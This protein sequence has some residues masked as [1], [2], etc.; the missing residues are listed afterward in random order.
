[1]V[2]RIADA[3]GGYEPTPRADYFKQI[4]P[5]FHDGLW[6]FQQFSEA[7][8]SD[9]VQRAGAVQDE[10]AF[11]LQ[12]KAVFQEVADARFPLRVVHNDTKIANILFREKT[13]TVLAVIDWDTAMPGAILSDFTTKSASPT[14]IWSGPATK[15]RFIPLCARRNTCFRPL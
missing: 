7:L 11:V 15:W 10:I 9:P 13:E 3:L 6:R 4:I 8:A 5:R 14:T 12:E 1:M 2:I